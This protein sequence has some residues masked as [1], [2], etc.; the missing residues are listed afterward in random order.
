MIE[1]GDRVLATRRQP[2]S[3]FI[4]FDSFVDTEMANQWVTQCQNII[5]RTFG[6]PSP[7]YQNLLK[8]SKNITFSPARRIQGILRAALDDYENGYLFDVKQLI[9][10]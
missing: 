2:P 8:E 6:E 10:G 4:G 9:T 5:L 3:N 7:H 1:L